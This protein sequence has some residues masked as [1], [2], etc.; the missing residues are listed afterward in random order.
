[1]GH[2]RVSPTTAS[3][4]TRSNYVEADDDALPQGDR[5]ARADHQDIMGRFVLAEDV[6]SWLLGLV[7]PK[8]RWIDGPLLSWRAWE[9]QVG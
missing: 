9:L 6:R 7:W 4:W 8:T 3:C 1:M 5:D 2:K